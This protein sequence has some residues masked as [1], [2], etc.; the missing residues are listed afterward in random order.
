[1]ISIRESPERL[2]VLGFTPISNYL[3]VFINLHRKLACIFW[4]A[5]KFQIAS[6]L[7]TALNSKGLQVLQIYSN[8]HEIRIYPVK[9]Y[10]LLKASLPK[11]GCQRCG[12]W[13]RPGLQGP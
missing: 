6:S 11:L 5:R 9:L 1:M 2:E 10:Y 8:M 7:F 13:T 4:Y 12:L 3:H